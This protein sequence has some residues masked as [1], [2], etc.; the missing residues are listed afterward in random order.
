MKYKLVAAQILNII[1][2][3][4]AMFML[5]VV[6][7]RFTLAYS[8]T[9]TFIDA[10]AKIISVYDGDTVTVEFKIRANIRMVDCWAPEIK[11]K[12]QQE[13]ARGLESKEYLQK[14][15]KPNDEVHVRV[16]FE[17]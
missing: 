2:S 13:K 12:N 10:P 3:Y 16:P 11:T 14:I 17:Y 5:F 7:T 6:A 9:E 15:L 4:C 1:S 8:K